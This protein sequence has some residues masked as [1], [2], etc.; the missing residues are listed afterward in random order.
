MQG[1][2]SPV[3]DSLA[4]LAHVH[5]YWLLLG[6]QRHRNNVAGK[7][8]IL[9]ISKQAM[10]ETAACAAGLVDGRECLV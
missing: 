1:V 3:A 6:E 5:G 2:S 4:S 8:Y 10:T 7:P 9:N